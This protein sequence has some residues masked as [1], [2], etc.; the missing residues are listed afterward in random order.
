MPAPWLF[1]S[2]GPLIL[3]ACSGP[4]LSGWM[5]RRGSAGEALGAD[6]SGLWAFFFFFE[7][8]R[9]RKGGRV[10][11][12]KISKRTSHTHTQ[13]E[14]PGWPARC[15][16]SRPDR[17]QILQGINNPHQRSEGCRQRKQRGRAECK[18][19]CRGW[20]KPEHHS[21][22][23]RQPIYPPTKRK[24]ERER[25]KKDKAKHW[26]RMR[27]HPRNIRYLM[28]HS[29][30]IYFEIS[31]NPANVA[32]F[33]FEHHEVIF[34]KP[35]FFLSFL[36]SKN[37]LFHY[38]THAA[39]SLSDWQ[40]VTHTLSDDGENVGNIWETAS[41]RPHPPPGETKLG[42]QRSGGAWNHTC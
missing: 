30:D 2:L 11:K 25:E 24:R 26:Q 7:R 18:D 1:R 12:R 29:V 42:R 40:A 31:L 38:T 14:P 10:C 41:S 23:A 28:G 6:S 35:F 33:C 3:P 16:H 15:V 4:A 17:L 36:I 27:L 22:T 39:P 9:E 19:R 37:C 20:R 13:S 21:N 8:E 5:Q 34:Q 32:V